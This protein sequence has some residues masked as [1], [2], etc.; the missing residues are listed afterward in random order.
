MSQV[1]VCRRSSKGGSESFDVLWHGNSLGKGKGKAA[2]GGK[3]GGKGAVKSTRGKKRKEK[4]RMPR[5]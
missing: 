4:M 1:E 2:K 3:A 5:A